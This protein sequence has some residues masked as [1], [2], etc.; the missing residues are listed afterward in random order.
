MPEPIQ[1]ETEALRDA[2]EAIDGA[3][4][5]MSDWHMPTG[6]ISISNRYLRDPLQATRERENSRPLDTLDLETLQQQIN[7]TSGY[8][9]VV[10][11]HVDSLQRL[12]NQA[13]EANRL[14]QRPEIAPAPHVLTTPICGDDGTDRS[15]PDATLHD[16]QREVC[17]T[18][19]SRVTLERLHL[20][21][22]IRQALYQFESPPNRHAEFVDRLTHR[23]GRIVS[24]ADCTDVELAAATA[25]GNI[26][27]DDEGR[28][29]ALLDSR[30][31]SR[32]PSTGENGSSLNSSIGCPD[33]AATGVESFECRT[34][35]EAEELIPGVD[36]GPRR[37]RG[38]E[39]RV[40]QP[41]PA[42][43]VPGRPVDDGV[44]GTAAIQLRIRGNQERLRHARPALSTRQVT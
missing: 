18:W 28:W 42:A 10:G 16:M 2:C 26:F 44:S 41:S 21:R 23:G 19:R 15:I 33:A 13:M 14:R 32:D 36:N 17:G 1:I 3:A 37:V 12:I 31:S 24:V 40:A 25:A 35:G 34:V 27:T 20:S 4:T 6:G 9:G 22:L 5:A 30:E 38:S 39:E 29:F 11:L 8:N 7:S 43:A